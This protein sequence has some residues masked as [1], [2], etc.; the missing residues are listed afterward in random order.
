MRKP[1]PQP[2]TGRVRRPPPI[3]ATQRQPSG[4]ERSLGQENGLAKR[5]KGRRV[6]GSGAFPGKPGDVSTDRYLIEC[7]T[8]QAMSYVVT[9]QDLIRISREAFSRDKTPLFQIRFEGH[10]AGV[11]NDW[12]LVPLNE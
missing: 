3:P 10:P 4:K 1:P 9:T 12:I 5:L 7:K 11:E 8:T 6:P 2:P